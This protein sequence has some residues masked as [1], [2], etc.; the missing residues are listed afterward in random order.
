MIKSIRLKLAAA[1]KFLFMNK[2][3]YYFFLVI[4]F[5]P[6]YVLTYTGKFLLVLGIILQGIG[7]IFMFK[8]HSGVDKLKG[9]NDG[10]LTNFRDLEKSINE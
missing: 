10:W 2:F 3:G 7:L 5:I 4:G 9:W 1:F 8:W 6:Y